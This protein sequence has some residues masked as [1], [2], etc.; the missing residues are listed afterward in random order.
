MKKPVTVIIVGA[1][2]RGFAYANLAR[3]DELTG[4]P[5]APKKPASKSEAESSG[6]AAAED[7]GSDDILADIE[8]DFEEFTP[9]EE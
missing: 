3:K 1:G 6:E 4:A 9:A 8:E 5:A 7:M 2:G